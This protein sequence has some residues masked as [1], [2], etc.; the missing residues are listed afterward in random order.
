MCT[1]PV[2]I[3]AKRMFLTLPS[4]LFYDFKLSMSESYKPFII[5]SMLLRGPMLQSSC[6]GKQNRFGLKCAT[7]ILC[8]GVNDPHH[9][10]YTSCF[11]TLYSPSS[12]IFSEQGRYTGFSIYMWPFIHYIICTWSSYEF[13]QSYRQ[14]YKET[15]LTNAVKYSTTNLSLTQTG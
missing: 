6:E 11:Y 4:F 1:L 8:H 10:P 15:C 12:D 14:Q 5:F 13:L 3:L 7:A 2:D 9:F